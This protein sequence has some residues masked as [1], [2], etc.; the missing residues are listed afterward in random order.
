MKILISDKTTIVDYRYRF[1]FFPSICT[2]NFSQ[3]TLGEIDSG[4]GASVKL[5]KFPFNF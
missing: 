4:G 3:L 2:K 5:F 1:C